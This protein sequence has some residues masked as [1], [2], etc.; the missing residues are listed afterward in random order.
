[1]M[2]KRAKKQVVDVSKLAEDLKPGESGG[3]QRLYYRVHREQ[4]VKYYK[5]HGEAATRE[6]YNIVRD[7]VWSKLLSPA[8][9][10]RKAVN[11]KYDKAIDMAIATGAGVSELRKEVRE[12]KEDFNQFVPFLAEEISQKFLI[13]LMTNVVKLPPEFK[14]NTGDKLLR[15]DNYLE[16]SQK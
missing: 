3:N 15:L 16:K 10:Q 5:L 8:G 4:I 7:D 9:Y 6:R 13:P 2:A 14:S 11:S 12:L 1:M